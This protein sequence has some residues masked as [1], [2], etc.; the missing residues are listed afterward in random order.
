[1]IVRRL[2]L[3]NSKQKKEL[4]GIEPIIPLYFIQLQEKLFSKSER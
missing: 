4:T 2:E 3:K 1:V